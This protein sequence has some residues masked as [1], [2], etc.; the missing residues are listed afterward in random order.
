VQVDLAQRENL[1]V[2]FM[3]GDD[4]PIPTGLNLGSLIEQRMTRRQFPWR[5]AAAVL[6]ALCG[7]AAGGWW[8]AGVKTGPFSALAA[9][10]AASYA[11][12]STDKRRPVELW[13]AQRDDL[14]RW[15]STR[16]NRQVAAPDLAAMGYQFIGGR[17]V[18]TVRGPGGM[19]MYENTDG[20]RLILLVRKMAVIQT[21]PIEKVDIGGMP[22]C[23]WSEGEMGFALVGAEPV[24]RLLDISARVRGQ[25][26]G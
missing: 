11:V 20:I 25:L 15:V 24:G 4:D 22:G 12:Y 10:T 7:G 5:T 3:H 9:D 19:F 13:A 26:R 14:N 1:R 2:A 8:F 21:T 6:L 16:L 23:A 17:L 18:P